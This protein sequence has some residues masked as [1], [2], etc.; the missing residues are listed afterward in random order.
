[1]FRR[2]KPEDKRPSEQTSAASQ[3]APARPAGVSD[4]SFSST[5]GRPGASAAGPATSRPDTL[6]ETSLMGRAPL[7]SGSP[8]PS[9]AGI[10]PIPGAAARGLPP[11]APGRKDVPD[12]RTLV[13]GRGISVQ[14]SVQD[15]ERLVVEGTVES[16]LIN[17]KE[18][19]V[20]PGGLFRGGV[21]VENAEIAGTVDGSLIVRG[22][23]TVRGTGRL[24]GKA[25]CHRLKVDDG[26]QITGQLEML[27]ESGAAPAIASDKPA[28]AAP[29]AE[30]AA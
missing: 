11:Q 27:P 8:L 12:Q 21:E 30:P 10:P 1:M 19:V 29:D 9:G 22:S 24:L 16:S 14:G 4:S 17:A 7:P 18:L 28:E 26:G 6:K 25:S 23:L 3:S 13:V 2:R 20:M 15:A 5:T